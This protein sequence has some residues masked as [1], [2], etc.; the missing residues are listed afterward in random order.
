MRQGRR[1][2]FRDVHRHRREA[3]CF[4]RL[5]P[6]V[7][8]DHHQLIVNH[9]GLAK[10]ELGDGRL[11][12]VDGGGVVARVPGIRHQALHRHVGDDHRNLMVDGSG[13]NQNG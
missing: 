4:S 1:Q 5:E 13:G 3:E 9:D 2:T 10:T 6:G 7:P 12:R 11:H 8:D